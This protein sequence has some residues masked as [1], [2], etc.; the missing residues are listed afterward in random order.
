M[1]AL[2]LGLQQVRTY[3]GNGGGCFQM[4]LPLAL[5]LEILSQFC[6][7]QNVCTSRCH[8]KEADGKEEKHS[9]LYLKK[10]KKSDVKYCQIQGL[11]IPVR[12]LPVPFLT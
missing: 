1:Q 4:C 11:W 9:V 2:S 7:T 6:I 8:V 12:D 5:F 10:K 3:A